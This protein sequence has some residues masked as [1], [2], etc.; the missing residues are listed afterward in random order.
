[1]SLPQDS[2]CNTGRGSASGGV[3]SGVSVALEPWR[4]AGNSPGSRI[5]IE[6][7]G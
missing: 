7:V 1:M 4:Y 3:I 5:E 2:Y 6:Q